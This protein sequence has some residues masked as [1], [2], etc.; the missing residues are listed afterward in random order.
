MQKL[1]DLVLG[2]S[3]RSVCHTL[4][5]GGY[6]FFRQGSTTLPHKKNVVL[7]LTVGIVAEAPS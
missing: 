4:E 6:K 2:Q 7:E 1:V 5:D 3:R